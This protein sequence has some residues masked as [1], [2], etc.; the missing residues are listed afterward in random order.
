MAGEVQFLWPE[1]GMIVMAGAG[2]VDL[3]WWW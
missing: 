2:E 3:S 1:M